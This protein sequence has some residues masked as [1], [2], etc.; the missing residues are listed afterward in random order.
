MSIP[1]SVFQTINASRYASKVPDIAGGGR[2]ALFEAIHQIHC[3]VSVPEPACF[4]GG[5]AYRLSRKAFG[6]LPI[7]ITT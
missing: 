5:V 6:C 3:V 7:R 1:E 2:L 4:G